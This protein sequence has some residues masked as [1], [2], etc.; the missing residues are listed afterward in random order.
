MRAETNNNS[1]KLTLWLI[2]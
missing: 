1:R 2:W